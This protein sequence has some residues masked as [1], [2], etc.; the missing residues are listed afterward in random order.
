MRT[1]LKNYKVNT[2]RNISLRKPSVNSWRLL[3]YN[4]TILKRMVMKLFDN[5]FWNTVITAIISAVV[6]NACLWWHKKADY[7]RDYYKK[8]VDKRMNAYDKLAIVIANVGTKAHYLIDDK[9]QEIFIFFENYRALNKA[10]IELTRVLAEVQW[11]S[12]TIYVELWNLNDIV[13]KVLD[14]VYKDQTEGKSWNDIDYRRIGINKHQQV[15][16][17][18]NKINILS[19]NDR[20]C[21][22][23]VKGFF[24]GQKEQI[25]K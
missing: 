18:I 1:K 20:M 13:A 22:D 7:K 6:T 23:D 15:K 5:A 17:L 19:I 2:Q 25:N 9:E 8:I 12:K 11:L 4:E 3:W 14:K 24:K 21:L 16:A 10:N